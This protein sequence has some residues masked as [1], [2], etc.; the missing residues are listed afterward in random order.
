MSISPSTDVALLRPRL[1]PASVRRAAGYLLSSGVALTA[2][3]ALSPQ[4]ASAAPL[5]YAQSTVMSGLLNP[6]GLVMGPDGA[7]YVAEAGRGG[8]GPSLPANG[9]APESRYGTTGGIS[10]LLNGVQSRV[11]SGLPSL[12]PAGGAE[13]TG[14]QGL[15]FG[16]NGGLYATIGLGSAP[17]NRSLLAGQPNVGLLGT[18]AAI[19][20]AAGTAT[21]FAN[22]ADFEAA[23]DPGGEGAD[24]N[25]YGVVASGSGFLVTDAG[26]NSVISVDMTGAMTAVAT[27]P[28]APTPA[29]LPGG[30][31]YQAVP[32]GAAINA[33]GALFFGQLTGFPFPV[34]GA[35]VFSLDN[36]DL[37]IVAGGLTNIIDVA[38]GADGTLFALELDSD[39]LLGPG[40]TGAIHSIGLD[41]ATA[42]IY[43]GIENPTGF[44]AGRAGEF[45]VSVYGSSPTD[46]AVM[47]LSPVPLPASAAFLVF[48][49]GLL[50]WASSRGAR[51]PRLA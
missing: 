38:F 46:G 5:A 44:A 15:A 45:F 23:N 11:V 43:G 1:R 37:S 51:R 7:L 14:P 2:A 13:A 12:A 48:A 41:G 9:G 42:L 16:A 29:G 39:S 8:D 17:A 31:F 3:F 19:D 50:G 4:A 6:R 22:L 26:G 32:T 20:T 24:S 18:L 36:G 10:R 35:N 33:D 30:P 25:P 21:A 34:G 40:T 47:R 49:V 27:L 28:A